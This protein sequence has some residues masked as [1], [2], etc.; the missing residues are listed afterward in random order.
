MRKA[1]ADVAAVRFYGSEMEAAPVEDP[2]VCVEHLPVTF[3]RALF[4]GIEAIGVLHAELPGSHNSE[5]R[6]DFITEFR[7]DLVEIKGKLS[8]RL[9]FIAYQGGNHL[10]MCRADAVIPVMPVFEAQEFLSIHM[11]PPRLPPELGRLH[12]R[13]KDLLGARP[14][15]L[16]ADDVFHLPDHA[17]SQGEIGVDPTGQLSY[18]SR[19]QHQLVTN[20]LRIRGSFFGSRQQHL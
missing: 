20:N 14:V 15:H 3:L 11:P 13:K 19:P 4:R 5:P 2:I 9:Y 12:G 17:V 7:L 18:Q 6:P 16:F 1:P 8:I 10:F